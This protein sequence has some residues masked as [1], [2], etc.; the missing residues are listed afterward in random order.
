MR[1]VTVERWT[2]KAW[3]ILPNAIVTHV[4]ANHYTVEVTIIALRRS[5]DDIR[6]RIDGRESY[7]VWEGERMNGV[8]SSLEVLVD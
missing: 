6:L 4:E 5:L 2:G 3:E 7:N 8:V 1:G